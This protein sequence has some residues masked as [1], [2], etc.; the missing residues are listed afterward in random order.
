MNTIEM[1]K[2]EKN[3]KMIWW[4]E[5]RFLM[6]VSGWIECSKQDWMVWIWFVLDIWEILIFCENIVY[7]IVMGEE[8]EEKE[9]KMIGFLSLKMTRY[10]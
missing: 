10:E 5:K 1:K 4:I 6:T 3:R 2:K 9:I 7:W 8:S